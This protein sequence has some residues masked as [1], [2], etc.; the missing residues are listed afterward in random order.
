LTS[1]S[2]IFTLKPRKFHVIVRFANK[3]D[4]FVLEKRE[5]KWE[6]TNK[7]VFT[8]VANCCLLSN[9]KINRSS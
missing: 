2:G 4:N 5:S 3:D 7:I 6:K 1:S 8:V 9:V